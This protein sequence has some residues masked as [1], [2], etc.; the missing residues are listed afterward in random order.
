MGVNNSKIECLIKPGQSGKTRTIQ[1][2]IAQYEERVP[3]GAL[4]III[5]S[6]NRKLVEQ[7]TS[8][9]TGDLFEGERGVCTTWASGCGEAGSLGPEELAMKVMAGRVKMVV[10][11]AHKVRLRYLHR[12]LLLLEREK[13]FTQSI[14][15]WIDEADESIQLWSG[16]E[17]SIERLEK[18]EQVTLVSATIGSIV[19]RYGEIRVLP[20][21]VTHPKAY[22]M[23][24]DC[25][26]V[27]D[28]GFSGS[29]ADYI[30][31]VFDIYRDRL[32]KPG[33]KLFAPGDVTVASHDAIASF[34]Q[35]RGFAVMVLNGR[36]KCIVLPGGKGAP[37]SLEGDGHTEV[38]KVMQEMYVKHGLSRYPFAVTGQLCLGRG[39]TFQSEEFMFDF[40]II[41]AIANDANAYQCACR[42]AGNIKEFKGYAKPTLV[43]PAE[44][45]RAVLE[46]ERIAVNLG[47]M[48]Y[49]VG[50]TEV[51]VAELEWAGR[52]EGGNVGRKQRKVGAGVVDV[53]AAERWG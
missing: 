53:A 28:E 2:R 44:R 29:G 26:L 18:V 21:A 15:I 9:M 24:A 23:I 5:C 30:M 4:N 11:C 37:I 13:T 45:L 31:S 38:G 32:C 16:E 7:T 22:H 40:G 33:M 42:L 12:L 51:G 50:L 46:Q 8:R 34:L 43:M 14:H 47:R 48:V 41:P 39:L 20:F 36:R 25:D 49:E 6:N 10:C 52:V 1:E 3:T 35:K 27:V 17:F 19:K